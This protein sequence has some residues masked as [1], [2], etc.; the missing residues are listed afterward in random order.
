MRVEGTIRVGARWPNAEE[1]YRLGRV[2]GS[3]DTALT[4]SAAQ[5]ADVVHQRAVRTINR[6]TGETAEK[7]YKLV[8]RSPAGDPQGVVGADD[9]VARI[10]EFGSRAHIIR[11]TAAHQ[12]RARAEYLMGMRRTDKAYLRFRAGGRIVYATEVHHPGTRAYRWLERSMEAEE[13]RVV[14]IY[15][16]NLRRAI[17]ES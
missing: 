13:L 17:E 11:P 8:R 4:L 16:R 9:K 15:D 3:V 5:A 10:L 12:A 6:R 14:S 2:S 7:I 1:E